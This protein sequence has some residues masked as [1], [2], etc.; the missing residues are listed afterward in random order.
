MLISFGF[1]AREQTGLQLQDSQDTRE[2][3]DSSLVIMTAEEERAEGA[4]K[5]RYAT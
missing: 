5:Q 4:Q 2:D 3:Q 1:T